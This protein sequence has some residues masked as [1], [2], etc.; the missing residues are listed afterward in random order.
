M[1]AQETVLNLTGSGKKQTR[2]PTKKQ[3]DEKIQLNQELVELLDGTIAQ[4]TED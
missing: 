4:L 2:S 3:K 1:S